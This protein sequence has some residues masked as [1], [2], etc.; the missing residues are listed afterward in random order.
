MKKI[1]WAIVIIIMIA[2]I[3]S[4]YILFNFPT[5]EDFICLLRSSRINKRIEDDN[6]TLSLIEKKSLSSDVKKELELAKDLVKNATE[7][8]KNKECVAA[9]EDSTKTT[10]MIWLISSEIYEE[11]S[12][13][14]REIFGS[15]ADMISAEVQIK[16]I[17]CNKGTVTI[18]NL[19]DQTIDPHHVVVYNNGIFKTNENEIGPHGSETF[20]FGEAFSDNVKIVGSLGNLTIHDCTS[21]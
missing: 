17:E 12:E 16:D 8:L 11:Y 7:K 18:T 5:Q 6:E 20:N 9:L 15:S 14:W 4:V 1:Y 19:K 10:A 2:L 21:K 13:G 3:A